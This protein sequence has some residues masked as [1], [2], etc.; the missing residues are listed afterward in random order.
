MTSCGHQ[1]REQLRQEYERNRRLQ[2]EFGVWQ[3]K[4]YHLRL[5]QYYFCYKRNEQI[6][7]IID[8]SIKYPNFRSIH[9]HGRWLY[10]HMFDM[11]DAFLH[12]LCSPHMTIATRIGFVQVTMKQSAASS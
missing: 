10:E 12:T 8:I 5:V 11:V 9:S 4:L 3:D 7:K 6:S 2:K 1:L